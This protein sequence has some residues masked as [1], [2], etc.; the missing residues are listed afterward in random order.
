MSETLAELPPPLRQIN[1][2]ALIHRTTRSTL[3][4]DLILDLNMYASPTAP[5]SSATLAPFAASAPSPS[6]TCCADDS[7][8]HSH[9]NESPVATSPHANDISS[10]TIPLPVLSSEEELREGRLGDLLKE[11]IW[12][13]QLPGSAAVD[14]EAPPLDLIRTKGFFLVQPSSLGGEQSAPPAR[15]FILQGVRETFDITEMPFGSEKREEEREAIKPKLVL[16]GRGLG[17][18]VEVQRRFLEA[19]QGD[20][21]S[22]EST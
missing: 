13:G 19:L 7:H 9:S 10:I 8:D 12:E 2:T 6:S 21:G 3:D 22:V 17:D 4:L 15:A 1:S 14:Q 11:L 5:L 20:E 16:I 18:G